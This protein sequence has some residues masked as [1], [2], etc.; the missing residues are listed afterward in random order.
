MRRMLLI[1][2]LVLVPLPPVYAQTSPIAVVRAVRAD[3]PAKVTDP[4]IGAMTKEVARRLGAPYGILRKAAGRN[5]AKYSCDVVCIGQGET[6]TQID[7]WI[8][9]GGGVAS[10]GWQP[11]SLQSNPK[12]RIDVC[13]IV[14]SEP[15]STPPSNPPAPPP[16]SCDLADLNT[17][18]DL[19]MEAIG[20][21]QAAEDAQAKQSTAQGEKLDAAIAQAEA[22]IAELQKGVKSKPDRVTQI[23][24]GLATLFAV[25]GAAR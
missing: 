10:P 9:S 3:Y 23:V 21:I 13:D 20:K 19:V 15:P 12:M 11:Q 24:S 1:L 8:N 4:Q 7:L 22:I 18:L 5:C 16:A 6:Q 17:R 2:A 14:A 25:L